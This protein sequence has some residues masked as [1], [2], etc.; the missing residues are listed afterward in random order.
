MIN[1]EVLDTMFIDIVYKTIR[2][3]IIVSFRNAQLPYFFLAFLAQVI[4]V[5][6]LPLVTLAFVFVKMRPTQPHADDAVEGVSLILLLYREMS[7]YEYRNCIKMLFL[8][9]R[10]LLIQDMSDEEVLYTFNYDQI[11]M[12][13]FCLEGEMFSL[14]TETREDYINRHPEMIVFARNQ[15][16]AYEQCGK[17]YDALVQQ[18]GNNLLKGFYLWLEIHAKKIPQGKRRPNI[19]IFEKFV[20]VFG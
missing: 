1:L 3:I 16:D 13:F 6:V 9:R 10:A 17:E 7:E 15:N 5:L 18:A 4:L 20:S 8:V 12:I 19:K 11:M 14:R 2:A